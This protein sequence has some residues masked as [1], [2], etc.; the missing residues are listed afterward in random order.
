MQYIIAV[1][2]EG[3]SD[4]VGRSLR[5]TRIRNYCETRPYASRECEARENV[6]G[7][8]GRTHTKMKWGWRLYKDMTTSFGKEAA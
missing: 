1:L 4:A 7:D 8:R 3:R 2:A 6:R 5:A